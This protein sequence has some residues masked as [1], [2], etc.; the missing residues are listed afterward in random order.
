MSVLKFS[1]F[2]YPYFCLVYSHYSGSPINEATSENPNIHRIVV[3]LLTQ[4]VESF[5]KILKKV[6]KKFRKIFP[7]R[8][9]KKCKQN[10]FHI[11]IWT[12]K[13]NVRFKTSNQKLLIHCAHFNQVWIWKII[14]LNLQFPLRTVKQNLIF[15]K[16]IKNCWFHS[17]QLNQIRVSKSYKTKTEASTPH[18]SIQTQKI[19]LALRATLLIII[20]KTIF[21]KS[22]SPE[23]WCALLSVVGPY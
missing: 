10:V 13:P 5:W 18:I 22:D 12:I 8:W 21:K 16:I 17:A 1:I 15:K 14:K 4:N 7:L 11:A 3:A 2:L 23:N 20:W 9:A 19:F 6:Q